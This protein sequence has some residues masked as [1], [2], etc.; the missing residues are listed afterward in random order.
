MNVDLLSNNPSWKTYFYIAIPL[1]FLI[2]LTVFALKYS[3]LIWNTEKR[4][5]AIESAAL[6]WRQIQPHWRFDASRII[7]V[8]VSNAPVP[9]STSHQPLTLIEKAELAG[10]NGLT[11]VFEQLMNHLRTSR[12][13]VVRKIWT[14]I[15]VL[16]AAHNQINLIRHLLSKRTAQLP[17]PDSPDL[18]EGEYKFATAIQAAAWAGNVE[19]VR[20]LQSNHKGLH[21]LGNWHAGATPLQ[22]ATRAGHESVVRHI[23]E[24]DARTVALNDS[25]NGLVHLKFD[26]S[27]SLYLA[28]EG[29]N[30]AI[31]QLFL[32]HGEIEINDS[33]RPDRKTA[34]QAAVAGSHERIIA[35]LLDHGADAEITFMHTG[36]MGNEV[37]TTIMALAASMDNPNIVTILTS[38]GLHRMPPILGPIEH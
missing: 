36:A 21:K 14:H 15:F 26:H 1:F 18:V 7:P 25:I 28:A 35:M 11:S 8:D 4:A 3:H 37:T 17:D 16:A 12:P 5:E 10:I 9:E 24:L 6:T 30:E 27:S 19:I 32:T 29:G 20:I 13:E 31:V 38:R 34:L 2:L 33:Y 23:L 22:A